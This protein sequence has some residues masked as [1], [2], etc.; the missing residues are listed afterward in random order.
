MTFWAARLKKQK[1]VS[2]PGGNGWSDFR[3][4]TRG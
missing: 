3:D 1:T 2:T 4:E